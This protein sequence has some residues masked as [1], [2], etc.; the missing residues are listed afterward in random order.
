MKANSD[1]KHVV[2]IGA[3]FSGLWAVRTFFK[4]SVRVTI[5]DKNNYHTFLPLLYQVGAAEIE[6]EQIAFPIRSLLRNHKNINYLRSEVRKIN[7]KDKYVECNNQ[8]I[9]FDYLIIATGSTTT[10]YN[11]EGAKEIAFSLK[12]LDDAVILRNH[13]LSCFERASYC[14]DPDQR[15]KLLSFVIVGGGPTGI[16]FAGALSELIKGPLKKDFTSISSEE[17]KVSL[18]D[19][20]D[21][22]L[23]MLSEELSL[24]AVNKLTSMGVG[25]YL[26]SKVDKINSEGVFFNDGTSIP[27][28]S[29][30]WT[31][32]VKGETIDSDTELSMTGNAR[33]RVEKSLQIK[34]FPFVYVTGDLTHFEFKGSPLP[35]IAP[36]A[37]QQGKHAAKN[38]L[39]DISGENQIDFVYRDK[40]SMVTIGR[41]SAVTEIGNKKFKGFSAW[42]I[43][44]VIHILNLIGFRNKIFVLIHWI[45]DYI[46]FEK[47]VRLILPSCCSNPC[48]ETCFKRDSC[49]PPTS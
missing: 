26:N 5:I 38:I 21:R 4:K 34:D 37:I 42:I 49:N 19:S 44:I 39:R 46:F 13:I 6:P 1:D 40:G 43:W 14:S 17:I 9:N 15:K 7:F 11:I 27:S 22:I 47:S 35:M 10:Y 41:N 24:Y 48:A 16:E 12:T 3:G 31:A 28:E 32:G 25:V 33:I 23:S 30:I 45:W 29:V 20:A 36:V 18:I 8:I 2:I